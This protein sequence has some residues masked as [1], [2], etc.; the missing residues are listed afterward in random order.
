[1]A[2]WTPA[3][4]TAAG[5]ASLGGALHPQRPAPVVAT[6][7]EDTGWCVGLHHD[8]TQSSRRYLH[9]DLL[10]AARAVAEFVVGLA[11][12]QPLGAAH[13]IAPTGRPR[14]HLVP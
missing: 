13:P 6:W 8:P 12:G 11:L 3:D 5:T 7:D 4:Q 2:A 9:P 1:M 10:P 14:L